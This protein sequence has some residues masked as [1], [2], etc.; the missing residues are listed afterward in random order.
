MFVRCFKITLL[1]LTSSIAFSQELSE[2][3]IS[4]IREVQ[5]LL[6]TNPEKAYEA[7][8][9]MEASENEIF[10]FCGIY[11]TANYHYNKSDYTKAKQLLIGLLENLEKSGKTATHTRYLDLK[12]MCLN[13]LFYINKNQGEYGQALFYLD[14]YKDG[15]PLNKFNE[16]YGIAK[17]ALGN[18]AEGIEMLKNDA[19][20]SPHL[21]LGQGESKVMNDKL[22][23]D[24]YNTIGE[25][26][27]KYYKQSKNKALLDS[28]S[29][30]FHKAAY[31]MIN[32]NFEVDY[33][34][35]L[36]D[37]RNANSAILKEQYKE[38]LA[39]Y[40]KGKS[41]KAINQNIRTIQLFDLGMAD[42]F[43]HLKQ[44]DEA[45]SYSHKYIRNYEITKISKENLL[46]AYNIL[47]KSYDAGRDSKNAYLYA[48]KSLAL[49]ESIDKIKNKSINFV[50]D[51]DLGK[52]KS[53]SREILNEKKYFKSGLY[54]MLFVLI[55]MAL[56]F[57]YYFR[58]QKKKHERFL[59]IIK[60][61]KEKPA[62]GIVSRQSSDEKPE[63]ITE[64]RERTACC[65]KCF[66]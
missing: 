18:Y 56:S 32:N 65:Q 28:A 5:A 7:A 39:L 6:L 25:S 23:A 15:I 57:Y 34:K 30:Y 58:L 29:Y 14:K 42:C 4:R 1:F 46:I 19:D 16:Q 37:L 51:Y 59:Q 12:A 53:E 21:K 48:R 13:K 3:N 36:L 52:I 26:Y 17:I 2:A 22:F 54:A 43:F 47:S 9:Q 62:S 44:Y 20:N 11:Y 33:T 50:Y 10:R 60:R 31:L 45:I 35:A 66:G 55:A 24:K 40:Q 49:I 41:Y 63:A 61:I 38:A 8:Q 27:Q 64:N